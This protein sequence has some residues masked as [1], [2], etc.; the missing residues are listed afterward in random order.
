[1]LRAFGEAALL[2]AGLFAL[3]QFTFPLLGF[4]RRNPYLL[5]SARPTAFAQCFFILLAYVSL[6]IAF[7][8]NDF[9]IAYVAANSHPS[10]PLMYRLTAVWGEHEGSILLWILILNA[11]SMAYIFAS[12]KKT[13]PAQQA[14]SLSILGL[15]GLCFISFLYFTSNPFLPALENL[16]GSD[17][18]PLLQDP[19]F[20]IHPPMLYMGYVGF[21]V[22]FAITQAALL[23]GQLDQAWA[24]SART[25][26][27]AAWCFLTFGI[28]L[29]SWW[30]YRVLGWGGFWFWDPVENS[31]LLPWITGIALVHVLMLVEK[32]GIAKPWAA[33]LSIFCFA[34]SLL[35]TFLVRSG[36]LISVHTFANDPKRGVYLLILLAIVLTIALTIYVRQI[37]KSCS[38]NPIKFT[39]FSRESSLL[40]NSGLLFIAMLTI[41]L[42]TL[43]PLIRFTRT[44]H[45]F[46]RPTLF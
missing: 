40:M 5:A 44:R 1:M 39:L 4:Y 2:I 7:V 18:N 33:L 32:R 23:R 17:L 9:S 30:A 12:N 22:A 36:V 21:S 27:T 26:A 16:T 24:K 43:Y 19:G 29:G 41:L 28:T 25:F 38:H 3:L 34:L 46:G 6:T 8:T 31:S 10:L 15:I 35:G 45:H 11:W 37:S 42:G 14:L 13:H 20:V